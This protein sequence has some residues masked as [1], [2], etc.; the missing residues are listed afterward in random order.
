[1]TQDISELTNIWTSLVVEMSARL[2]GP[3]GFA[4][5]DFDGEGGTSEEEMAVFNRITDELI[6]RL[7]ALLLPYWNGERKLLK[8]KIE[9]VKERSKR[10]KKE[11][12]KKST[13]EDIQEDGREDGS[14]PEGDGNGNDKE[15]GCVTGC[16][17]GLHKA[18]PGSTVP[19]DAC[20]DMPGPST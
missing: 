4:D 19:E 20:E 11:G 9:S 5:F 3:Q 17:T 6:K 15:T 14:E 12:K 10:W 8:E 1:M 7:V 2:L 18:L 13:L 16:V